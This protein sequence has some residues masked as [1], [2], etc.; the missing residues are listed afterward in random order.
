MARERAMWRKAVVGAALLASVLGGAWP[1]SAATM[2]GFLDPS[3]M[4]PDPFSAWHWSSFPSEGFYEPLCMD[5]L[6]FPAQDMWKAE[7][8][9]PE[10][11]A[12][13][14]V[15]VVLPSEAEAAQFAARAEQAVAGCAARREQQYP[16]VPVAFTDHGTVAVEEGAHVYGI[17]YQG[18]WGYQNQLIAVGR[19][20]DTVTLVTWESNWGTPP[21]AA[22]KSTVTTA[23]NKLR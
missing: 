21:V 15:S 20:G 8:S 13:A 2:P 12:G 1:A 6:A 22:F 9:T 17:G 4:P 10:T 7:Y 19:D 16:G 5:T 3:E 14:Q 18:G 23:V 11:A